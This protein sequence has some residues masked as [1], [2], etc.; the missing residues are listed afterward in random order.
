MLLKNITQDIVFEK[1]DEMLPNIVKICTC[2]RCR[3]DIMAIALNNLPPR[4]VVTERGAIFTRVSSLDVQIAADTIIELTR[5][6]EKVLKEPR[7][8]I[9]NNSQQ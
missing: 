2:E 9:H 3:Y 8:E 4:Y 5:A 1:L 7:H 6:I